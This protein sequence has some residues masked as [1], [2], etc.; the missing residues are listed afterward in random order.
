MITHDHDSQLADIIR[1]TTRG[2]PIELQTLGDRPDGAVLID[3]SDGD[4]R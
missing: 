2:G 3:R 4:G 1:L